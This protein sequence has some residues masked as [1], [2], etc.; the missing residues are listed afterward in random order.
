[1]KDFC[2]ELNPDIV[3]EDG[4]AVCSQLYSKKSLSPLEDVQEHLHVLEVPDGTRAERY[5]VN[6][7][8]EPIRGPVI[9]RD[10]T[11][12]CQ[13][14]KELLLRGHR[15]KFA[16]ANSLWLGDVPDVLKDLTL[17]EQTLISQVR[18]NRCVVRVSSGH[19]K[20]VA[21][22]ISFEHPSLKI[23][24]QLPVSKS[25]LDEVL[26]VIYTGIAALTEDDLKRT[27]VLVQ[28]ERVKDAL[29]WLRLNHAGYADLAVD[30]ATLDTYPL[31]GVPVGIRH[32]MGAADGSN[33]DPTAMSQFDNDDE[34]GTESGPCPF[35]VHGLTGDHVAK[36][37]TAQ[38]KVGALQHLKNGGSLLAVG[39]DP[40]PQS[41]YDNPSLYPSMFPWLFPYGLGGVGQDVHSGIISRDKHVRWLLMYHDKCFQRDAGFVI[42]TFNH[43]LIH[44]SMT[45]S[46][47][48]AKRNNFDKVVETIHRISPYILSNIAEKMKEGGKFIPKTRD[49]KDCFS[50]LDQIEYVGGQ[51]NGSLASKKFQRNELWSLVTF[52]NA[53]HWFITLS[54][55]D[56][57]HP[58]CIYLASDDEMFSPRIKGY[59]ERQHL[60]TRNPVACVR[61]FDYLVRLFIKHVCGWKEDVQTHGMFGK[62]SGYYG[63][64]EQQDRMTLHLHC[65]LWIEGSLPP[66]VIRDRLLSGDSDFQRDL[67]AYLDS[68]QM[69]EF[70]T[71]SM[72]EVKARVPHVPENGNL[73][74]IHTILTDEN[75]VEVPPGISTRH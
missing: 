51:V 23:Y 18:Y 40:K 10:R 52:K 6:A 55:A 32:Q 65:L 54:P 59:A 5:A 11:G 74:G 61:F 37:T 14:C 15:P 38:R 50:L 24:N 9:L 33:I 3:E 7:P 70:L 72:D 71:G 68:C 19:T 28:R 39:H 41:V 31:E 36:M 2:A 53:P 26:A 4:C 16:L 21:N 8:I 12:V 20:M 47:M 45:G 25:A 46:F 69:G 56:N 63:M 42:V 29:E 30:Y 75:S 17:A 1:M 58:L 48:L 67:I 64:V 49:E 44:Q 66:Q 13:G 57:K 73:K 43:Q 34:Q 62:P 27:P 35:T 60:V 22:V